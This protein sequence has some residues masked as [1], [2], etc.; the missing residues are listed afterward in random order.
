MQAAGESFSK[1]IVPG[2]PG[3]VGAVAALAASVD[4]Q[5]LR[6]HLILA[7]KGM[8][9]IGASLTDPFSATRSLGDPDHGLPAPPQGPDPTPTSLPQS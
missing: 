6:L 3:T 5:L 7:G 2:A 4:R 8:S 1:N 9:R